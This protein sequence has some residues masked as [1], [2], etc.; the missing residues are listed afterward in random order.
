MARK[1][2]GL[3]HLWAHRVKPSGRSGNVSFNGDGFYSYSTCIATLVK[4]T[5]GADAVLL[6]T[7]DYSSTTMCHKSALR[8]A[9]SHMMVFEVDDL[10]TPSGLHVRWYA[11]QVKAA[12]A[13]AT[14]YAK[15]KN[16]RGIQHVVRA[17]YDTIETAN[18]FCSVF[19]FKTQ[20]FPPGNAE[21]LRV[22][23]TEEWA[24]E[25]RRS[26]ERRAANDAR[27]AENERIC[28]LSQRERVAEFM[29]IPV[30][31][32]TDADCM[33]DHMRL[34][35]DVCDKTG[36]KSVIETTRHATVTVEQVK[37]VAKLVLG[38]IRSGKTYH[39]NGTT[40]RVGAYPLD[41]IDENGTV[42]VGCHT[43]DRKEIERMAA[44]LGVD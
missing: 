27:M 42:K 4:T 11:K 10:C 13:D 28:R 25:D 30:E 39:R 14:A 21:E 41:S 5:D 26:A 19:G 16:R 12:I 8:G 2:G 44:V 1:L 22:L 33:T 20:F 17:M 34:I 18:R 9:A 32:V 29:G 37:R 40:M 15:R 35:S 6:T 3:P 24:K 43:F 23:A 31:D 38:T 7:R 36:T